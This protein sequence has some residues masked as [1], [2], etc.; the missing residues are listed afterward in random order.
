MLSPIF[1]CLLVAYYIDKYTNFKQA[2]L[3][4]IILGVV[5]GYTMV[6][7]LIKSVL[8]RD[9]SDEK[10]EQVHSHSLTKKEV[11]RPK[12]P[13]RINRENNDG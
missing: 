13:S 1:L 5:T 10:K 3:P 8:D 7:K 4:A 11:H 9:L 12:V 2:M 6:Y